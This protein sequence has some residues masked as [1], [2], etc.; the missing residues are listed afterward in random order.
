MVDLR[1]QSFV[2]ARALE[3]TVLTALRTGEVVAARWAEFDL[4]AKVWTVPAARMK[5][6][7]EHRVPLSVR[8]I[9]I[10]ENMPRDGEHVFP[11]RGPAAHYRP[12]RCSRRSS[13]WGMRN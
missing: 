9:E 10:L 2:T 3:L 6:K 13:V 5:A 11:G 12:S 7:R 4:A 8:A 1:A